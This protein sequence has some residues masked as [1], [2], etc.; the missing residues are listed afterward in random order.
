MN[1]P[2]RRSRASKDDDE[3]HRL[4]PG[5]RNLSDDI[6]SLKKFSASTTSSAG[7]AFNQKAADMLIKENA[8]KKEKTK[9]YER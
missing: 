8:A 5:G 3:Y 9:K 4:R 1:N 6:V 2:N 7:E